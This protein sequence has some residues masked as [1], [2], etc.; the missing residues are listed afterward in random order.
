MRPSL[1]PL[2]LLLLLLLLSTTPSAAEYATM[3]SGWRTHSSSSSDYSDG[4]S[5]CSLTGAGVPSGVRVLRT[6]E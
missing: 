6:V 3:F 4:S 1:A 2:T 5:S